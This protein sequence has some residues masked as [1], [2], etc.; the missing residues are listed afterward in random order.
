MLIP[1]LF[2]R[3]RLAAV[4]GVAVVEPVVFEIVAIIDA[5]CA[6]VILDRILVL[7]ARR[8]IHGEKRARAEFT[9]FGDN[10]D[11]LPRP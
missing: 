6:F 1:F 3:P 10:P 11:A 7:A 9:L 8:T 2:V 4:G 5:A